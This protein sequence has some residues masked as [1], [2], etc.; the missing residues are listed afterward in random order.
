MFSRN[1]NKQK[2]TELLGIDN[3]AYYGEFDMDCGKSFNNQFFIRKS[4]ISKLF[5]RKNKTWKIQ[6]LM[7]E[8]P[9]QCINRLGSVFEILMDHNTH[10]DLFRYSSIE[11]SIIHSFC[12]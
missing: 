11:T 2:V 3:Y 7:A 4:K 9:P 1:V 5:I 6:A 10:L 12:L 8:G